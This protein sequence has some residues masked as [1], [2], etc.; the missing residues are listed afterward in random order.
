M[1]EVFPEF[2]YLRSYAKSLKFV[3][4]KGIFNWFDSVEEFVICSVRKWM[5]LFLVGQSEL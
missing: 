1:C 2:F 5:L 4:G 3:K